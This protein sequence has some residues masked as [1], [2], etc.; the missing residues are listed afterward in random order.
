MGKH[1]EGD[2]AVKGSF[3]CGVLGELGSGGEHAGEERDAA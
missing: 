1:E 3:F 2:R